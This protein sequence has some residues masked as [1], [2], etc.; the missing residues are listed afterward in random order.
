M[1]DPFHLAPHAGQAALEKERGLLRDQLAKLHEERVFALETEGPNLLSAY[2]RDVGY[3]EVECLELEFHIARSLREIACITAALN[4][5]EPVD[6]AAIHRQLEDEFREWQD[7]IHKESRKLE[8]ARH[9]LSSLVGAEETAELRKRYRALSIQLH[10]DIHPERHPAMRNL[11]ERLQNAYKNGDLEEIEL[12]G[13]LVENSNTSKT[14]D[15]PGS[16]IGEEITR[17]QKLCQSLIDQ[18]ARI[19]KEPP[20]TFR[21]LLKDPEA[22]ALKKS[23]LEDQRLDLQKRAAALKDYLTHLNDGAHP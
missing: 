15:S 4:R 17:L 3:L 20:H 9:R 12:I 2:Y 10:P 8:E 18:L 5:S 23:E 14:P 21:K 1:E 11:W 19:R 7:R 16:G 22:V 6:L 13:M